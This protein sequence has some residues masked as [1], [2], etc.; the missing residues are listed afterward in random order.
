MKHILKVTFLLLI[1]TACKKEATLSVSPG[2]LIETNEVKTI[3]R[4]ECVQLVDSADISSVAQ[5]D[6]RLIEIVY[7]T[8]Y[9]GKTIETSGMLFVPVGKDT[10]HFVTYNH[11]TVVPLKLFK[12]DEA[13]PSLFTGQSVGF[14][15]IRNVGLTWAS[16]GYTVFMP[17]YVGYNRTRDKEHPYIYYPE[18]FK[19]IYH[20]DLAVKSYI[21]SQ[22]AYYDNRMFLAGWSQGGGASLSAHRYFEQNYPGTFTIVASLNLSGPYNFKRF[23]RSVFENKETANDKISIY[24]WALYSLNKFSELKRANDRFYSYS[25]YD[26]VSAFNPPSTVPADIFNNF[27]IKQIVDGSDVAMNSVIERNSMINGWNPQGKIYLYHGDA[28]DFVPYFNSEDCYEGL[29]QLGTDIHFTTYPGA[30]HY[31]VFPKYLIDAKNQMDLL[32]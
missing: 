29:L 15:E 17:D 10:V 24:S 4:S 3:S 25:V 11:G 5:Y 31:T 28:D 32:K 7:A 6:V 27:F 12:M 2:T 18:L 30:T 20:G 13:T 23:I 22:S 14:G 21:Q 9:D 16:A 19:S 26:Q 1:F 8:E